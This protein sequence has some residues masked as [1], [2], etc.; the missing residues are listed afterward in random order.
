MTKPNE[1]STF[2]LVVIGAGSAGFSAA[3]TG[4]EAGARVALVNYGTIGGT[5]VNVGCVP[6]KTLIRGAEVIHHANKGIRFKGIEASGSLTDWGSVIKQKDDLVQGLRQA[7]YTDLLP[8]YPNITL[9]EGKAK[10]LKGGVEVNG[11]VLKASKTI[12][13]TGSSASVPPIKGFDKVPFLTSTSAFELEELP[14]SLIIIGGGVIGCEVGQMFARLGTEVTILCRSRL[15]PNEE[16]E[17]SQALETYLREDGVNVVCGAVY[18][19]IKEEN[20]ICLCYNHEGKTHHLKAD[21]V[22]A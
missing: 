10:I 1:N 16:P 8:M 7:K 12:I 13:T 5:C 22:L 15:L 9:V 17:I 2:D 4:A 19:S 20:G 14:E 3:I 11:T 21:H 6:S 18:Q